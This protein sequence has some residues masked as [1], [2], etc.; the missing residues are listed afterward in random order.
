M[1]HAD[2]RAFLHHVISQIFAS[3]AS[4]LLSFPRMLIDYCAHITDTLKHLLQW[5]GRTEQLHQQLN[6]DIVKSI[7]IL[8][9]VWKL[10]SLNCI[11]SHF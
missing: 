6:R 8:H 9:V 2:T 4:I 10:K 11:L 1:G 5:S 3:F 7:F